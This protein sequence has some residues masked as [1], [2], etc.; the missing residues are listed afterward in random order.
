MW[1]FARYRT[2]MENKRDWYIPNRELGDIPVEELTRS[3]VAPAPRSAAPP[4]P[5][6]EKKVERPLVKP[7]P[8]GS[9]RIEIEPD[10]SEF[11]KILKR[12]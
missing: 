12:P 6:Q 11:G 8:G 10:E 9:S 1:T 2:W 3:G 7:A 5:V 4:A